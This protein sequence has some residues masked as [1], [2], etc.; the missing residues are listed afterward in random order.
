[1][2]WKK[3]KLINGQFYEEFCLYHKIHHFKI[4]KILARKLKRGIQG[5]LVRWKGY[6]SGFDSWIP[7]IQRI[8]YMKQNK[9]DVLVALFSIES[10]DLTF[11][12][13]QRIDLRS[14]NNWEL[15]ISE[16]ACLS[17]KLGTF[18]GLDVV[19]ETNDL[20]FSNFKSPQSVGSDY[21]RCLKTFI[22]PSNFCEHLFHTIFYSPVENRKFQDIS[23]AILNLQGKPLPFQCDKMPTKVFLH[24]RPKYKHSVSIFIVHLTQWILS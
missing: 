12:L 21:V 2:S 22:R 20:Y 19:G 17:P 7:R 24:F 9:K 11:N 18:H 14:T 13:A 10:R 8:E 1:M 16:F 5:C 23:I 6:S 3:M 15:N 4:Y